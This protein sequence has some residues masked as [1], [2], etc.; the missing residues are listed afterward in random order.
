[1]RWNVL[2][3]AVVWALCVLPLEAQPPP[4]PGQ[5]PALP[6]P[7]PTLR[8][9][10]ECSTSGCDSDFMRTELPFV[11][12]VRNRQ[13]ADVHVLA[14]GRSTGSGGTEVTL[15]FTGQGPFRG[16][17]DEIVFAM[18]QNDS[19]DTRRRDFV[20]M[21]KLGLARY[22]ARID[23]GRRLQ[24]TERK[25][26][27]G[28]PSGAPASGKD[29]WDYWFFRLSMSTSI[30]GETSNKYVYLYGSASANRTTK[31]WKLSLS[32]SASHTESKYDFSDGTKYTSL[33][34]NYNSSALV[35]KSLTDHW[36][37]G[38]TASTSTSSYYNQDLAVKIS[39]V[40]EYNIFP[41][42]ESTRRM[43]T[44]QYSAAFNHF[45]Y[46]EVTLFG[47]S[48]EGL[49]SHR[50]QFTA[51]VKQKWGSISGGIA[52]SQFL[53]HLSKY[54]VGVDGSVS[55]KLL[56]GLSLNVGS[57]TSW[58]RDQIYLPRGSATNE[59]VLVR[60]RQLATSYS[61]YVYASISYSFGSIFN[62]VVN[63][64]MGNTSGVTYYY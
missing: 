63:P 25:M 37:A 18:G 62:N 31:A 64:R 59:E 58:I 15:K 41:Y 43:L 34:R 4:P 21:L 27:A 36:S 5:P 16:V 26:P 45:N 28:S 30:S 1:M 38:A 8:L 51:D 57:Y 49:P 61:Y 23:L 44:V 7:R 9:Y 2:L 53:N 32:T 47:K 6:P 22:A 29:P 35:V 13:D 17:D 48:A 20:Q 42:A 56:K 50:L 19:E 14:T 60:Q 39:P 3:A 12:H 10:V 52:G 24:L 33:R 55:L 11:D 46:K 40:V 54:N